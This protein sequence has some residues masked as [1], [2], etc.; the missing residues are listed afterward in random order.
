MIYIFFNLKR[1]L[2][3]FSELF[4]FQLYL[5]GKDTHRVTYNDFI[6]RELILFSNM[7][8]TRSIASMVD[9][10]KPG[11]R[12]VIFTCLKRNLEKKEIK[13]AQLAGSVGEHSAYH[14]GEVSVDAL[15][16]N[17]LP[18]FWPNFRIFCTLVKV[19]QIHK[20]LWLYSTLFCVH[21]FH[22][23]GTGKSLDQIYT[24]Y[25]RIYYIASFRRVTLKHSEYIFFL[26]MRI[27]LLCK[28]KENCFWTFYSSFLWIYAHV[29]SR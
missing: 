20:T 4:K 12:K 2:L 5:Y 28:Q 21:L 16:L 11:Q 17:M 10:L 9:G 13:V 18:M 3:V 7:D 29:I 15:Y 24:F 22:T 25:H 19:Y 23:F 14:H 8:N 26:W 27:I 1:E 6:N